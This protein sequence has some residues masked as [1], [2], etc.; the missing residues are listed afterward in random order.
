MTALTDLATEIQTQMEALVASETIIDL[1]NQRDSDSAK[2]DTILLAAANQ[3][4]REVQ[5]YLGRTVDNTD[6]DAVDFGVRIALFRLSSVY[7]MTL[8]EGGIAYVAGVQ[9]EMEREAEA[10]RQ[11]IQDITLAE[12]D[13]TD[14]DTRY[15][16]VELW[17]ESASDNDGVE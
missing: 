14:L 11:G 12:E 2:N 9:R 5:R 1:T 13:F 4:A 6:N 8:H 7:S 10:R 15:G 17:D 3:A 16:D